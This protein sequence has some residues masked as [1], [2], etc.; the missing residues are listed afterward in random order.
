[1]KVEAVT[2]TQKSKHAMITWLSD[3]LVIPTCNM[4]LAGKVIMNKSASTD[5]VSQ[6][7]PHFSCLFLVF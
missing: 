1:M 7:W 6:T 3:S 5:A 4:T 2:K